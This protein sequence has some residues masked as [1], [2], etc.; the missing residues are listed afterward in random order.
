MCAKYICSSTQW[1]TTLCMS[2]T[3]QSR[4]YIY[5]DYTFGSQIFIPWRF[6]VQSSPTAQLPQ[7]WCR[8]RS[9][10]RMKRAHKPSLLSLFLTNPR[11]LVNKMDEIWLR[12]TSHCMCDG[13]NRDLAAYNGMTSHD[14]LNQFFSRFDN[15]SNRN[16]ITTQRGACTYPTASRSEIHT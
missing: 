8:D 6:Y 5:Q 10:K 15:H 7:K 12:I 14:A 13:K 4:T 1:T 16:S 9:K 3:A 2:K 11:S